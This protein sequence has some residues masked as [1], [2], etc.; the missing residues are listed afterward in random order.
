MITFTGRVRQH[1]VHWPTKATLVTVV[2][3]ATLVTAATL[4]YWSTRNTYMYIGFTGQRHIKLFTGQL[5][6]VY[7]KIFYWLIKIWGDLRLLKISYA[8]ATS[9]NFSSAPPLS[10]LTGWNL[11]A[12]LR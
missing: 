10:F 4:S 7:Q 5:R 2:S 6:Q 12:S 8:S 1:W 3:E 11:S 9:A